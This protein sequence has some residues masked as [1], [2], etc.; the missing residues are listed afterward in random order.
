[1]KRFKD[2]KLSSQITRYAAEYFEQ[3][4]S[5]DPLITITK[6]DILDKGRRAVVFFTAYPQDKE[7]EAL[8][9]AKRRRSDFRK[10]VTAKK[11]LGFTPKFD[12]AIDFGEHNRQRID[13]L[14][15][16]IPI[17]NIGDKS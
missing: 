7:E 16:Q 1:M 5:S 3:E 6:T 15:S 14:L 13:E 12:F 10:F 17:E 9:F 8:D 11:N 4:S 2:Q